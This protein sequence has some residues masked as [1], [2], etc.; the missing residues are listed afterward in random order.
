MHTYRYIFLLSFHNSL[1]P[2]TSIRPPT[3]PATQT[4]SQLLPWMEKRQEAS[5]LVSWRRL[6]GEKEGLQV[7]RKRK[8]IFSQDQP[9]CQIKWSWKWSPAF[10][11]DLTCVSQRK[12]GDD[13]TKLGSLLSLCS[14]SETT[15]F[16]VRALDTGFY[17]A[18]FLGLES[19]VQTLPTPAPIQSNTIF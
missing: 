2:H 16:V 1:S 18:N 8:G 7:E 5:A 9:A 19:T 3:S 6:F 12:N 13:A 15:S 10:T 4:W 11:W 17:L 14:N